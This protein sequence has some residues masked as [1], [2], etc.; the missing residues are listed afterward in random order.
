[1]ACMHESR[2]KINDLDS[3]ARWRWTGDRGTRL[4][5]RNDVERFI[6]CLTL[7]TFQSVMAPSLRHEVVIM[8]A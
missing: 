3:R 6:S 2:V 8:G 7:Q 1:M 5:C 4:A